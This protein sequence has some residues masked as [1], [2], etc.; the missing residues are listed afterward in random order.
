MTAMTGDGI[1]GQSGTTAT[2]VIAGRETNAVVSNRTT[3]VAVPHAAATMMTTIARRAEAGAGSATP[4]DIA[5]RLGRVVA[6]TMTT[7]T[8]VGPAVAT[9]M[10]MATPAVEAEAGRAIPRDIRKPRVAVGKSGEVHRGL[11]VVPTMTIAANR[12]REVTK[13]T[14]VGLVIPG[15]MRRRPAAVG[16]SG[17]LAL[18]AAPITMM[19]VAGHGRGTMTSTADGLATRADT[20]K[21]HGVVGKIVTADH[22]GKEISGKVVIPSPKLNSSRTDLNQF[23]QYCLRLAFGAGE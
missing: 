6:T 16:K 17:L 5:K 12:G 18:N 13:V 8:A 14:A 19:I 15:A 11:A 2:V 23:F 9:T 22:C 20:Q 4:K 1:R 7:M 10:I 3:T 21:P